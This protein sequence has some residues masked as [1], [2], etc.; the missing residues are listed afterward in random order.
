MFF[1]GHKSGRLLY[2]GLPI[3]TMVNSPIVTMVETQNRQTHTHRRMIDST[4]KIKKK[5]E[6][7]H[8]GKDKDKN[9]AKTRAA[10]LGSCSSPW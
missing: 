3:A 2:I 4:N 9:M 1:G 6:N 8:M 7:K 5:T 10:P